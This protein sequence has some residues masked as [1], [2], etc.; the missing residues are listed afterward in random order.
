M[1]RALRLGAVILLPTVA[2]LVVIGWA[3][4]K[5]GQALD[6]ATARFEE[7]VRQDAASW[8]A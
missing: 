5:A 8:R 4:D 7:A 6:E 3:I 1:N 2:G